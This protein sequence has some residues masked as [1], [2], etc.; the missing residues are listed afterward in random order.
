[1]PI[2][3]HHIIFEGHSITAVLDH[4]MA[5]EVVRTAGIEPPQIPA[6]CNTVL[7]SFRTAEGRDALYIAQLGFAPIA[8]DNEQQV[9]GAMCLILQA[10]PPI[11][12]GPD[13][14]E[15]FH[16]HIDPAQ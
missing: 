3:T 4:S 16:R 13:I 9:N 1:M 11:P 14:L 12:G 7:R 2:E 10:L 6:G 15:R 8:G 5:C